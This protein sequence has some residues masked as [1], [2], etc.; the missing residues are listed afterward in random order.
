MRAS[1][2]Q[3]KLRR[4][5]NIHLIGPMGAILFFAMMLPIKAV[6]M[7]IEFLAERGMSNFSADAVQSAQYGLFSLNIVVG[8]SYIA[9]MWIR[10]YREI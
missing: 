9:I 1:A 8:L 2:M 5:P 10:F 6:T 4:K 3:Q 7:L